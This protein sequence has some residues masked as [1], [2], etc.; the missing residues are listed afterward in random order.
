MSLLFISSVESTVERLS[1]LLKIMFNKIYYLFTLL[2]VVNTFD[3]YII[4]K[5][6]HFLRPAGIPT[7]IGRPGPTT[8]PA[9]CG[10]GGPC[11]GSQAVCI[12]KNV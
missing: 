3:V 11:G 1:R 7:M 12:N 9:S 8:A 4:N 2:I 5:R 10:S 6:V